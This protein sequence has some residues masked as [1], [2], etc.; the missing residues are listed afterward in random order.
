LGSG[1]DSSPLVLVRSST[2]GSDSGSLVLVVLV[3][4]LVLV[5]C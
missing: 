2:F 1:S 5:S 4:V 3:L